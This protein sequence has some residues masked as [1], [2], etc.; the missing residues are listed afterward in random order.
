LD[1]RGSG[2]ATSGGSVAAA[3]AVFRAETTDRMCKVGVVRGD[4]IVVRE[5]MREGDVL[6]VIG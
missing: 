4:L 2:K 3:Q 1:A 6:V 5:G